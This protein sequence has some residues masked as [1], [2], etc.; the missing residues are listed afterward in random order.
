MFFRAHGSDD[1]SAK[2]EESSRE[3]HI[4]A[5]LKIVSLLRLAGLLMSFPP[6]DILLLKNGE[7]LLDDQ[8]LYL[9]QGRWSSIDVSPAPSVRSL[10]SVRSW[11][12]VRLPRSGLRSDGSGSGCAGGKQSVCRNELGEGREGGEK[13]HCCW[14][15]ATFGMSNHFALC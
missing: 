9:H 11:L 3:G 14:G 5:H 1:I 6:G 4:G 10:H 8:R 13:D 15:V 7:V 2:A 12:P